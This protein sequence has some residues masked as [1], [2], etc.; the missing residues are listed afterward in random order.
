MSLV[1]RKQ[2]QKKWRWRDG[3]IGQNEAM[4]VLEEVATI[5]DLAH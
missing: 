3:G 4:T 1:R 2:K 5:N